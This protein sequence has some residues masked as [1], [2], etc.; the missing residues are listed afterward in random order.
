MTIACCLNIALVVGY[1]ADIVFGEHFTSLCPAVL[2]GKLIAKLETPLRAHANNNP[3]K[4]RRAGRILVVVVCLSAHV[5]TLALSA[6]A[7]ALHPVFFLALQTFWFYQIMATRCL[8]D[9]SLPVYNALCAN[10]VPSARKEVGMIVGRDTAALSA[11]E[12]TKAAVETVA[13]NTSDGSI[14]PLLYFALGG[15]PLAM[16]YKAI[17]TMDSMIGYKNE[18]YID[19]GRCA[20]LLDDVANFIPSRITAFLFI[21]AAVFVP[22]CSPANA[23]RIW[24]RDRKKSTSPNS[25][26]CESAMAGALGVLLLGDATYFGNVVRKQQVGDAT[27]AIKASDI[28][29]SHQMMFTAASLACA[30]ALIARLVIGGLIVGGLSFG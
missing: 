28:I 8:A 12:C 17:N 2:L 13:E 20:A 30:A 24:A 6:I 1:L 14:A 10:D 29:T 25:G 15:A 7:W 22:T 27:R 16:L 5:P 21:V 26:Q 18:R 3:A 9:A 19:F 11:E 23:A 4:L